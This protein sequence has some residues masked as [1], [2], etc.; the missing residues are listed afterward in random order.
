MRVDPQT[1][2]QPYAQHGDPW[3]FETS[4]YERERYR[5]TIEMIG[6]RHRRCFEPGCS[7]GVLTEQLATLCDEVVAVDPS[8]SAIATARR[9]LAAADNVTIEVGAVPEWWPGG[10]FDLVVLSELGYY[11]DRI[12]LAALVERVHGVLQSPGDLVAVHWL[13]HSDDHLL[14]GSEVHEVLADVLG[15]PDDEHHHGLFV[16]AAWHR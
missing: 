2:E 16:S 11:W 15:A 1:F 10:S 9:R 6:G 4:P 8:P 12:E 5:T 7:I 13:G 3:S 14:H